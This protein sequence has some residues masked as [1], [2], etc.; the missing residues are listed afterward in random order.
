MRDS[1]AMMYTANVILLEKNIRTAANN[2]NT[3]SS[4]LYE[5]LSL[6]IP[7]KGYVVTA[8]IGGK[9]DTDIIPLVAKYL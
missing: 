9:Y 4:V 1:G 5:F 7:Y 6:N 8:L 2:R 3:T